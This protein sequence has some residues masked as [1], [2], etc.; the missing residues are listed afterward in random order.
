MKSPCGLMKS[1]FALIEVSFGRI[2]FFGVNRKRVPRAAIS[3][4]K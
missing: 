4:D 1:G 3:G 2:E